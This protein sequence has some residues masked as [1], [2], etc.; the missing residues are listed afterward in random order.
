MRRRSSRPRQ[1]NEGMALLDY[2]RLVQPWWRAML[3]TTV[4]MIT[5]T[6]LVSEYGV[7]TWYRAQS[8]VRPA[9]QE[10]PSLSA[11]ILGISGLAGM[12]SSIG[13]ILG[14]GTDAW[15]V[16]EDVTILT[17]YQFVLAVVDKMKFADRILPRTVQPGMSPWDRFKLFVRNVEVHFGMNPYS[18]Y[19]LYLKM[20]DRFDADYDDK[21]G[22]LNL[23]FA[24]PDPQ[25]AAKVLSCYID[26]LREKS[27]LRAIEYARAA[28]EALQKQTALTSDAL[29]LQQLD[30]LIAQQVQQEVTAEVQANFSFVVEEEPWVPAVQ[31][32][33]WVTLNCLLMA[34]FVPTLFTAGIVFNER[35]YKRYKEPD[36]ESQEPVP[37]I[38]AVQKTASAA[39]LDYSSERHRSK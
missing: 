39:S 35:V 10:G 32:L 3:I 9:T 19:R 23:T 36:P 34:L 14:T 29:L 8:I 6:A 22:N 17:S 15:D 21:M 11:G 18:R 31:Y 37:A 30:L 5:V 27:R 12:S 33:P 2:V 28:R 24:D 16:Q 38:S 20:G 1:S 26:L 25:V 13:S 7:T 4:C